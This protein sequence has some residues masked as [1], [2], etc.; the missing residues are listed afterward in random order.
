MGISA[1]RVYRQE[2]LKVSASSRYEYV[3]HIYCSPPDHEECCHNVLS[4]HCR[5]NG[6]L[7]LRT[8]NT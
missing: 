2:C 6:V 8:S 5:P 1:R 4:K 7:A 3:R